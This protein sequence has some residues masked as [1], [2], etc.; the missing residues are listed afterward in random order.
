MCVQSFLGLFLVFIFA[1]CCKFAVFIQYYHELWETL[2]SYI[3]KIISLSAPV[4]YCVFDCFIL[5][6]TFPIFTTFIHISPC[7]SGGLSVQVHCIPNG[8]TAEPNYH[9][10]PAKPPRENGLSLGT[11]KIRWMCQLPNLLFRTNPLLYLEWKG[12]SVFTLTGA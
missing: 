2:C 10:C 1:V 4:L 12:G 7:F 3:N 5:L 11:R 9:S 8:T 6:H